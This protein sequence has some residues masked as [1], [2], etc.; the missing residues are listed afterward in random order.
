MFGRIL[1]ELAHQT[2]NLPD[3]GL[4]KVCALYSRQDMI[5]VLSI[6]LKI[7]I[8]NFEQPGKE[9]KGSDLS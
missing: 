9:K 5:P 3:F 6:F 2:V 1:R 7:G 8:S 4:T